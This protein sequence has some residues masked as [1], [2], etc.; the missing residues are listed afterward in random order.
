MQRMLSFTRRA[1]EN[2][3]MISEGDRIVVGVSGGKDSLA[4][5]SAL[6]H[7]RIF[8]PKK[9]EVIAVTIDNGFKDQDPHA[10]DSVKKLCE[11]LN[12]QY[13]IKKTQIA[14]IIFEERKETNPCSLCAKMRRGALHDACKELGANKLALGHNFD[15]VVE[16]FVMNLFY[17]G[18]IGC[19]KPV[20]YLSR[21]DLTVIR[22]LIYANERDI[23][24][25]I[26]RRDIQVVQSACPADKTT[27][28]EEIKTLLKTL[29]K[30][31]KNLRMQIFGAL[32]R[33]DIDDWG[34][35]NG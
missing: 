25:F 34:K 26:R 17:E 3:N 18:R 27:K 20:T 19:F 8:Y 22:P 7:M 30:D 32:E 23:K 21:K 12:V 31:Y 9:Y 10:F 5:L 14:E 29:E 11:E 24:G 33:A 15:D 35:K 1:I 28:R 2:Y 16:T 13:I 6:S 4:I